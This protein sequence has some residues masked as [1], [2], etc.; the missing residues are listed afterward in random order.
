MDS[1]LSYPPL[2]ELIRIPMLQLVKMQVETALFFESV[3][4][5]YARVF[6]TVKPRTVLPQ[7]AVRFRKYAN[8]NSRIRLD[9]GRLRVDITDMLEGAPAP[10]QEALAFILIC[11]LFRKQPD[12]G[13]VARYRRY[14]NRADVRKTIHLVKQ[15]RGRKAYLDPKGKFFDLEQVFEELNFGYFHGLMARPELGWSLR[16]SRTTLGHYDPSHNVIVLTSILDSERASDLIIKYIMFHEMLHL[17]YPTEHR[18]ARRCVHTR[19]FKRAERAFHGYEEANRK[20][21]LFLELTA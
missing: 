18:G 9:Q 11:K 3:E 13:S 16:P 5:I 15:E 21:K 17:R 1:C 14:L 10:I 8:A 20:L 19:E 4:Q 6:R 12:P 7:I 2:G